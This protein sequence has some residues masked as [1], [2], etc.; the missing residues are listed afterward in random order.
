MSK[1]YKKYLIKD[2][3]Y[4]YGVLFTRILIFV[5][6]IGLWELLS[7][8]EIINSFVFSSPSRIINTILTFYR[9]NTLLLHIFVTVKECIVAFLITSFISFIVAILLY[10]FKFLLDVF[11]PYLVI[12]NSLPKV[13]LGPI[14]IILFGANQKSIIVMAILISIIVSIQNLLN[15]F[16]NTDKIKINLL[17]TFGASNFDIIFKVV[18][19]SNKSNIINAFKINISMCLIGVISGEFLTSKEGIGHLI[20]YGFQMFNLNLV[21][22]GILIL[23][24]ISIIFYGLI[25]LFY[26]R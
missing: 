18:I 7:N 8:K 23:F 17:K 22:S 14:I 19:P 9:Q 26:R 12:F 2:K 25:S 24:V 4:G 21:M 6:F 13:A 3:I 10:Q 15:G 16:V 11:D 20:M 5:V 1:E